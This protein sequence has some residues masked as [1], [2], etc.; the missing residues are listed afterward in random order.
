MQTSSVTVKLK[1]ISYFLSD[2]AISSEIDRIERMVRNCAA[3]ADVGEL[4]H[5]HFSMAERCD[6]HR[7][8]EVK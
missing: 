1:N 4:I 7:S 6:H 8:N 5:K 3:A 2:K